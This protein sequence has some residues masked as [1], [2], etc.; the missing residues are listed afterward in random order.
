MG[1]DSIEC[2]ISKHPIGNCFSL[3]F[4]KQ[5]TILVEI[6]PP[7][8]LEFLDLGQHYSLV[9]GLFL[10]I[11]LSM[12]AF[13]YLHVPTNPLYKSNLLLHEAYA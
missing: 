13:L 7:P 3:F 12:R 6:Y 1:S 4:I 10:F 11:S 5:I 2:L 8:R 9:Q